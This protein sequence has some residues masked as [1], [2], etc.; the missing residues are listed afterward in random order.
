MVSEPPALSAYLKYAAYGT[1]LLEQVL[2]TTIYTT[3]TTLLC[4]IILY[5]A[6]H[7]GEVVIILNKSQFVYNNLFFFLNSCEMLHTR[8]KKGYLNFLLASFGSPYWLYTRSWRRRLRIQIYAFRG[9]ERCLL[10]LK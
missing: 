4:K 10:L 5:R 6:Q 7:I 9:G 1:I 2:A 3:A 8:A